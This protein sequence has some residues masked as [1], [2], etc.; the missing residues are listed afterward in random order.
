[1]NPQKFNTTEILV[2]CVET[3][4]E[5]LTGLLHLE[6]ENSVEFVCSQSNHTT[7]LYHS[8]IPRPPFQEERVV[9]VRD[10]GKARIV[11]LL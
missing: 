3:V 1:M 8:L 2:V 4:R 7:W 5:T 11:K 10:C 6:C 9:W